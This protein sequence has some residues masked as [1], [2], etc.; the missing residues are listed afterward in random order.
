MTSYENRLP[1][2]LRVL[3]FLEKQPGGQLAIVRYGKKHDVL[4]EWVWNGA[5]IDS[6][7]VIW[8]RE[9]KPEWTSQLLRYYAGRKA[10]LV[11]PDAR[12][13]RVTA[14]PLAAIQYPP[15]ALPRAVYVGAPM[16]PACR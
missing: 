6:Q 7:K 4:Y 8:A 15:E 2:R 10:W 13:V 12:P 11:E 16:P 14:Y 3:Q 9:Q 1:D 5:G